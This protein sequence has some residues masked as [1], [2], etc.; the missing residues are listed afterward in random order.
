MRTT[1]GRFGLV[2]LEAGY[3]EKPV[4]GGNE[5]GVP[6]AIAHM[7][8]GFLVDPRDSDAVADSIVTLLTDS[9]LARMMGKRGR[10]RV[11][12]YFNAERMARDTL[13]HV[14]SALHIPKTDH[15]LITVKLRLWTVICVLRL[16]LDGL[17]RMPSQLWS[18][19]R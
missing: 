1:V 16:F 2:Y 13:G 6:E 17:S 10:Q 11:I 3:Y 8:S 19:M 14:G 15:A 12:D 18:K 4:I 5:G 9:S 7:E